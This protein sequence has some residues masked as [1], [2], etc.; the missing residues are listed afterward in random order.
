MIW[1]IIVTVLVGTLCWMAGL[2]LGRLMLRK[3][4]TANDLFA[5][6]KIFVFLALGLYMG[7]VIIAINLPQWQGLPFQWRVYGMQVTW[8]IIRV[9]LIGA[10]G[11]GY[12]ICR[13]TARD[14]IRY[15][16]IVGLLGLI[17]FTAVEG[18]F[19]SPI[20]AQLANNLRLNRVY[21]Q[22]S[23]SSCAPA[24]LAT[25][26]QRWH[27]PEVTESVAAKYA[28]TSRMGT[29]M[30]QLLRAVRKLNMDSVELSPTWDQMRQINRPGILAVWQFTHF[31]RRLPHAV[32]L[33]AL[34][35]DRAILADPANGRYV[36][37]D[38][39][40]FDRMWRKEYLPVYRP[41]DDELTLP[42]ARL[43]LRKL[44]YDTTSTV[45]A[46]QQFQSAMRVPPTGELDPK[47][48]LL[49]TG[50]FLQ[51]V[52]TLNEQQ[53]VLQVAELMN[54]THNLNNCPWTG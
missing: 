5:G 42:Q 3:G 12:A 50:K 49:L 13:K 33:M 41:A 27:M 15:V 28:G 43:Y 47:T 39:Q 46:V 53:F 1:E 37:L 24:A 36:Q 54:C 38:R 52:P 44:G 23:S 4:A 32:A 35:D 21:R 31:G 25:L 26:F 40:Q 9:L 45:A 18:F 19:L 2:R 20:H 8:T 48:V 11:V 6:S 16:L 30:P 51:D 14:Q 34:T 10:C 29:S 7:L 17:C 22:S